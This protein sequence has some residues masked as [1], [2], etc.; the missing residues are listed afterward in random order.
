M[1]ALWGNGWL[2]YHQDDDAAADSSGVELEELARRDGDDAALRNALTLRG[3]VAIARD[4]ATEAL[5]LLDEALSI[6]RGLDSGWIRATSLLNLGTAHLAAGDIGRTRAV[7]G[8]AVAA[9]EEIGDERFRA[10]CLGYLGMASLVEDDPDRARA[11][12]GQSLGTFREVGERGGTAEGLM[13]IAA[14]DAAT[15]HPIRA[16][17]LAGSAERLRDSFAGRELPLDRK[18]NGRFLAAAEA[19]LGV[20]AWAGA[21]AAGRDL[22][23]DEAID[24]ALTEPAR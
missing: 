1:T 15:G 14:V 6:A 2:A 12:F 5:R 3:M 11:L 19:D 8:E 23:L 20:E 24:L 22:P 10:R 18:T 7:L 17:T 9:Y 21:W 4:D 16:A 13:G